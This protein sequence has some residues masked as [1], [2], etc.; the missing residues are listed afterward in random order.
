LIQQNYQPLPQQQGENFHLVGQSMSFNLMSPPAP[1]ATKEG[2]ANNT[3]NI[4]SGEVE[5][6]DAS[7]RRRQIRY[8]I[9]EEEERLVLTIQ[10]HIL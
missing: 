1:Q 8:W 5:N 9:H 2:I 7:N 3:V 4:D 6:S 10:L